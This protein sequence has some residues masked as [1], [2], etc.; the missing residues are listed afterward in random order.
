MN[1]R[2]DNLTAGAL[3]LADDALLHIAETEQCTDEQTARI[4]QLAKQ[5]AGFAETITKPV[6]HQKR[7][8]AL[9]VLIAAAVA[10]VGATFGVSAYINRN[11]D[12]L[13]EFFGVGGAEQIELAELPAPVQYTNGN[14]CIT[15]ETVLNDGM[16]AYVL[17]SGTM[18]DGSPWDW[19][20]PSCLYYEDGTLAFKNYCGWGFDFVE[21]WDKYQEDDR[22][23]WAFPKYYV[24]EF[25][26]SGF[27]EEAPIDLAF[28]PYDET[29]DNLL[30]G[31]RIPLTS[32]LGEQNTPMNTYV[33]DSS[34][35]IYLSAFE[36]VYDNT[37][38][39]AYR[40]QIYLITND[41]A[42]HTLFSDS[43]S[44]QPIQ[45]EDGSELTRN[46][47]RIVIPQDE[48]DWADIDFTQGIL[49][50]IV[51]DSEKTISFIDVNEV[52]AIEMDGVLYTLAE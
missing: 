42:R 4:M 8:R 3:H 32:V 33:S 46:Y 17:L 27:A 37:K 34:A 2:F 1:E 30:E 47:M 45:T 35:Q 6:Q 10:A 31:I 25:P 26:L 40:P 29:A 12:M 43:G 41:D 18:P 21:D 16:Q 52:K 7:L 14:V 5:K 19:H 22:G 24:Y 20:V 36:I 44:S 49:P 15:V 23:T 38:G 9:G 39:E 13:N 50:N 11:T 28:R 48:A 51:G